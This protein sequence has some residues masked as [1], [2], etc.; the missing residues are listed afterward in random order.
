M[1][2]GIVKNMMVWEVIMDVVP[3]SA[4]KWAELSG[5]SRAAI[6]G[7]KN[8]RSRPSEGALDLYLDALE[9]YLSGE[10]KEI[11][12]RK[13]LAALG[14][15]QGSAGWNGCLEKF[16]GDF[17]AFLKRILL[18][19]YP[20]EDTSFDEYQQSD[21]VNKIILYKLQ[22]WF[23]SEP[24][25]SVEFKM[26]S[27]RNVFVLSIGDRENT[28]PPVLFSYVRKLHN[29]EDEIKSLKAFKEVYKETYK[30]R[31]LLHI[32][33][34]M[35]PV[36]SDKYRKI[37]TEQKVY[38]KEIRV[39][40]YALEKIDSGYVYFQKNAF[41]DK[42]H[43]LNNFAEIVF[44]KFLDSSYLIY[45]EIL[46]FKYDIAHVNYNFFQSNLGIGNYP[47][48]M[49][50]AISF[51]R[52]QI[53]EGLKELRQI[54]NGKLDLI[55]DLNCLGGLY[56]LRLSEHSRQVLCV[57]GSLKTVEAINETLRQFNKKNTTQ[58]IVN[59]ETEL[60]RD[61]L[62]EILTNRNLQN[63]AD[64]IIVGLGT[65]SYIKEPELF[66]KKISGWLK[67]D[68]CVF[69]SC[70]NPD[71]LS[72]RMRKYENLNYEYDFYNQRFTYS[73]NKINISVPVRM[74]SFSQFRKLVLKYFDSEIGSAW[75]YPI[76]S[77]IFPVN[78]YTAE[79]EVLKEVDKNS[80]MSSKYMLAYG[81]Y[82]M[83]WGKQYQGQSNTEIY[84]ETQAII[85]NMR[86]NCTEIR[87]APFISRME[88]IGE[89]KKEHEIS[90]NNFIKAVLIK[91]ISDLTN[92]RYYMIL[93]PS[94]QNF[95][96]NLLKV[97]YQKKNFI[98]RQTK[99]KFCSE[100]DLRQFGFE[101]GSVCPFSFT[102][103]KEKYNMELLYEYSIV[104]SQYETF[105]TYSGRND[106][107]YSL[108]A[109]DF[110]RYLEE[111]KACTY[112]RDR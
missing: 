82:N 101:M 11:L 24:Q 79:T 26:I 93:L 57:D 45:K 16:E 52:K 98:Y 112:R 63:K 6:S 67:K 34:T 31:Q 73:R 81:N 49:R 2:K 74:F 1:N 65:M 4:N 51:E 46:C 25:I 5:V 38:L 97:H 68:G 10:E 104:Q 23:S 15:L 44:K 14:I 29:V 3:G 80:A 89:L 50:R 61:E 48:A 55:V 27:D 56:G 100:R 110:R 39:E 53:E 83:I 36:S 102:V 17:S 35:V 70:Y 19:G 8:K 71:S 75:S 94:G 76:I 77:S 7:W 43:E 60:F 87:H 69:L 64:C 13:V 22:R 105:Y 106:V 12:K 111:T 30:D 21:M 92:I 85:L 66:M 40:D 41:L 99:M 96:W 91:D 88:L 107:T 103:L 58:N 18:G 95:K 9:K 108:N 84:A 59:V 47:Y 33:V 62:C 37:L 20:I 109:E 72:V 78:E 32:A 54:R 42:E 28:I 90:I 86:I